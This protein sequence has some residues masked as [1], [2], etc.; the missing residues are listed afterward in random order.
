MGRRK[1]KG[2]E[3]RSLLGT[4]GLVELKASGDGVVSVGCDMVGWA[5]EVAMMAD[6][7]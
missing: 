5:V 4:V 2:R 6:D 1:G 3:R 7:R